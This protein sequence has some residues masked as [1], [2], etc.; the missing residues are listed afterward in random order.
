M[1]SVLKRTAVPIAG[2]VAIFAITMIAFGVVRPE[3][4]E[5][6]SPPAWSPTGN[7]I[8]DRAFF[9]GE[10]GRDDPCAPIEEPVCGSDGATYR[11]LC[12]AHKAGTDMRHG[13]ACSGWV[14]EE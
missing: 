8:A 9:D 5:R 3:L 10:I 11:N 4:L 7:A 6:E 12:E 2:L 14:A 1:K 13:G